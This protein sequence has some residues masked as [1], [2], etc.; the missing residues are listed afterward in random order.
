MSEH[1]RFRSLSL[2]V[3]G[4]LGIAGCGS[5][6]DAPDESTSAV[7]QHFFGDDNGLEPGGEGDDS[8]GL[9][10][11][12]PAFAD[13]AGFLQW[14]V[15]AETGEPDGAFPV[16][17]P[18]WLEAENFDALP[19]PAPAFLPPPVLPAAMGA[20]APFATIDSDAWR[21]AE[22]ACS[23]QA[24]DDPVPRRRAPAKR[25]P[26]KLGQKRCRAPET[27]PAM[28]SDCAPK[29]GAAPDPTCVPTAKR[30]RRRAAPKTEQ[31]AELLRQR[32]RLAAQTHR[33]AAKSRANLQEKRLEDLMAKGAVLRGE[34]GS[35]TAEIA[36]LKKLFDQ[37]YPK[38]ATQ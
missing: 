20:E 19:P 30:R 37:V 17:D 31:Q 4:L 35:L 2:V 6:F 5:D 28:D 24:S 34:A 36:T 18:A 9:F 33:E 15:D 25:A 12:L 8:D 22:P 27:G 21:A 7:T 10:A 38:P 26:A 3:A 14:F 23:P 13:A 11:G 1:R 16:F 29:A 32:N